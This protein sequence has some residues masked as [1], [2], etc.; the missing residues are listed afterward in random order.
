MLDTY[1]TATQNLLQNPSAPTDL[2][3]TATLTTYINQARTWLAGD[4]QA[5]KVLG[6]F[7]LTAG[8]QGPYPFSGITL[9]GA[10]GVAGVLNVRQLWYVV[11]SG[12]L[13]FRGRAWPWFTTYFMNSAAPGSGPPKAW[14]QYGEGENGTLYVG[15]S[16][17]TGYTINADCVCYPDALALDSDPEAIPAPWTVAVPYFAAYLALLSAQ[18]GARVQDAQRMLELYTQF[19]SGARRQST[20]EIMSGNFPQQQSPVRQNQLGISGSGG[21]A[22]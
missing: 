21:G 13:W 9:T 6:T 11:G 4:S 10:T 1:L 15:P 18:T 3:D 7:S 19:T 22:G 14:A 20:P 17:D 5:I 12:Q 2:Y 16:P 8:T